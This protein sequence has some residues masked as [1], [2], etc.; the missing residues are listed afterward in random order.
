LE[1]VE[2]EGVPFVVRKSD[3]NIKTKTK[4]NLVKEQFCACVTA[5]KLNMFRLAKSI[6]RNDAD[7]EDATSEAILKAYD[8]LSYLKS[9]ASFK[10]WIFKIV[11][12]EAYSLAKRRKKI[13]YLEDIQVEDLNIS[14]NPVLNDT[15]ELWS[16][17]K[18]LDEEFRTITVL[19]YYEDLSIKDISKTLDLPIGTVKSRLARARQKLK[20]LLADEGRIY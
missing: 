9:F 1:R 4:E 8:N 20:V 14:N 16:V 7:A 19:F 11:I 17:V 12:N 10:P 2:S 18:D 3:L 15:G 13:M 6:L 5:Y